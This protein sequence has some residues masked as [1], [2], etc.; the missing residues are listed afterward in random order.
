MRIDEIYK[1]TINWVDP[2]IKREYDEV[3]YQLENYNPAH[4]PD[5][6]HDRLTELKD[7]RV[8]RAAVA[9]A[10]VRTLSRKDV[11]AAGNT[12][13]TWA[14][15]LKWTEPAK[16]KRAASLYGKDKKVERPIYLQDPD[17]GNIWLLAGHH[18]S[19]YVTDVLKQPV[20]VA[21]I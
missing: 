16:S 20:E 21:V 18:R 8:F 3:L 13:D 10:Q 11:R 19:T 7:R 9:R 14:Q 17:S 1:G 6:V 15:T 2:D 12:G 4:M 5:W